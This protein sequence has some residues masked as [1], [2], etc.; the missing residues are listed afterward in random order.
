MNR[1]MVGGV[2]ILAA[3]I[4]G[5]VAL[6]L[7]YGNWPMFGLGVGGAFL[8][9]SFL[10]D[11]LGR[12][13]DPAHHDEDHEH[14]A[15]VSY[16]TP[17][18]SRAWDLVTQAVLILFFVAVAWAHNPW[19]CFWGFVAGCCVFGGFG[20][21]L[22]GFKSSRTHD[23]HSE[24]NPTQAKSP[25]QAKPAPE[26]KPAPKAKAAKREQATE[27]Q[28]EAEPKADGGEE[29]AEE[30]EEEEDQAPSQAQTFPPPQQPLLQARPAP[31]R[32]EGVI[33]TP[34][35]EKPKQLPAPERR[36]VIVTPPPEKPKQLPAPDKK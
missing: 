32:I 7:Q 14:H 29:G 1:M 13:P 5:L 15:P 19:L 33:I 26:A 27:P 23:H 22:Q 4:T 25:P 6:G 12:G 18:G 31:R 34:P 10:G 28:Q 20:Y 30:E 17:F 2:L 16:W 3:A 21:C 24:D 11:F 35:P 9:F 36:K 8:V